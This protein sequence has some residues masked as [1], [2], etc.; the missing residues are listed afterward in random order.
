MRI[1]LLPNWNIASRRPVE[2]WG[3]L[4]IILL[5]RHRQT[6]QWARNG[7]MGQQT[8]HVWLLHLLQMSTS[9][10]YKNANRSTRIRA[11]CPF[12]ISAQMGPGNLENTKQTLGGG[13]FEMSSMRVA[14]SHYTLDCHSLLVSRLHG[15]L[16]ARNRDMPPFSSRSSSSSISSSSSLSSSSSIKFTHLPSFHTLR[17]PININSSFFIERVSI[18][19]WPT[20]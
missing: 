6:E 16:I 7:P 10:V 13:R 5:C 14:I 8:N 2:I 12:G 19:L 1:L 9:P 3:F 20:Y 15:A 18:S 4:W 11:I 17:T